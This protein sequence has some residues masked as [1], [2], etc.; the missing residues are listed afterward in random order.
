MDEPC[1]F[2]GGEI[3]V[4]QH[5]M[6]SMDNLNVAPSPLSPYI[7]IKQAE[8]APQPV[9]QDSVPSVSPHK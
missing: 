5:F 8:M 1:L 6:D 3:S 2:E 9:P 4:A 7:E